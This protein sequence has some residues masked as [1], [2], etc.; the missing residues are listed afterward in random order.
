MLHLAKRSTGAAAVMIAAVLPRAFGDL[1]NARQF[2]IGIAVAVMLE[3][4]V[5][6]VPLPAAV[7]LLGRRAW[8]PTRGPS[9]ETAPT[10][11]LTTS[12]PG[13]QS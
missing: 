10:K 3:S 8:W 11:P 9:A 7:A 12:T 2:A 6:P 1:L 4:I 5:R 13:V